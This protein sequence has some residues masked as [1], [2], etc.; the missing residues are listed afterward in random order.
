MSS[1]D[2]AKFPYRLLYTGIGPLDDM[3]CGMVAIYLE[4]TDIPDAFN[5]LHYCFASFFPISV[6]YSIE[7]LRPGVSKA[8]SLSNV[9]LLIGK[10]SSVG[11]ISLIYWVFYISGGNLKNRHESSLATVGWNQVAAVIFAVVVGNVVPS[12]TMLY[13]QMPRVVAFWHFFP[14]YVALAQ[15]LYGKAFPPSKR[16]KSGLPLIRFLYIS[17]FI[18]SALVHILAVW[19]KVMTAGWSKSFALP[20]LNPA[21]VSTSVM[22]VL[23]NFLK[24]DLTFATCSFAL[25]SLWFARTDREL[26][27]FVLWYA[28]A[29]P[30]VGIGAA[31]TG[32]FMYDDAVISGSK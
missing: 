28:I 8:V 14:A 15:Y 12:R 18:Y 31:V 16:V 26:L 3:L 5:F 22:F 20:L 21:S 17:S 2:R 27:G 29:V 10:F 24:W 4:L 9:F 11:V 32:V 13:L 1:V 23:H 6:I 7:A 30:T 25:G 19:P